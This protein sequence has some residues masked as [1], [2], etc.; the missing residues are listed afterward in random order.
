I[1]FNET[2]NAVLENYMKEKN[3]SFDDDDKNKDELLTLFKNVINI[4][5]RYKITENDSYKLR[6]KI[7][8]CLL[9]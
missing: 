8:F 6:K 4:I 9:C 5:E 7:S 1:E 2:I 3:K